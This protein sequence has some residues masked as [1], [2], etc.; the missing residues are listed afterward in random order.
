[1]IWGFQ[2]YLLGTDTI[3]SPV[4]VPRSF[5]GIFP[6]LWIVSPHPCTNQYPAEYSKEYSANQVTFSLDKTLDTRQWSHKF[7][8][9]TPALAFVNAQLHLFNSRAFPWSIWPPSS[10]TTAWKLKAVNWAILRF[11]SFV[12]SISENTV[13]HHLMSRDLKTVVTYA[14]VF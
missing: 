3:P 7:Q 13:L 8:M 2:D 14:L 5:Q 6:C 4:W 11:I 9:Q 10:W 1:M 12:S